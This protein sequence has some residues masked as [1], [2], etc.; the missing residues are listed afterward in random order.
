MAKEGP[1]Q[2]CAA[3]KFQR[4]KCS[5]ECQFAPYFPADQPKLFENAHSLFGVSNIL[6][7]LSSIDP[8]LRSEAMRS[9]IYESNIRARFPV[10]GCAGAIRQLFNQLCTAQ[11][12]LA[13][14]TEQIVSCHRSENGAFP[15]GD[16]GDA[17][18]AMA[19]AAAQPC[20]C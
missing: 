1:N 11:M 3:C 13:S 16:V 17:A 9:I 7:I 10:D 19:V 6:K 8:S 15:A 14:L 4:R 18:M 12:E 5:A 20:L 2:A